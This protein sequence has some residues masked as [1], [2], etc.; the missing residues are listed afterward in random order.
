MSDRPRVSLIKTSPPGPETRRLAQREKVLFPEGA[1]GDFDER[2]FIAKSAAGSLIEDVDGNRYID[3]GSG[4]GTNN[5]GNCHPEV[6]E[7]VNAMMRQAGVTCWTSAGN[8]LQRLELAEKLLAV[9]PKRTNKVLFLTT[10]TE[11][12]EA[13]LRLMRRASGRPFVLSFFGQYHGLSYGAMAAGPLN[14]EVREDVA[15]LV[16]GFVYAPY[17]YAL[18][19]PLRSRTG[20]GAGRATLEFIEEMILTYEVPA[21]QIAGVLVEPVVGEAGVWVPPDDFLP[22]LREMCDRHGWYLCID[23]VQSGFGR[24]GKMWALEHWGVEP[25]LLVIGK[26]LSGG[27]MPIAAVAAEGKMMDKAHAFLAGTYAGH[28]AACAAGLKTIEILYRDRLFEHATSLGEY[29]LQRLQ[30]MQ[31]RYPVVGE[32]RGKGLWLAAEF[33]KDRKTQEKNFEAAAEVNRLCLKS[34]LYYIADSISWFSR[35]QPP[36]NIDRSLFEQGLDIFEE[37]VRTVNA[38]HPVK[39]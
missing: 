7:A 38:H 31:E 33:V 13:A 5:I 15:P 4:W 37:A 3:F 17:P 34:G 12:V 6:V 22:G 29:G 10:G 26:G 25:D 2:V 8:S 14:S 39:R 19:T 36:L 21:S 18:R 9:C 27:S 32:V 11:A 30:Q 24:C 1:Y 35:F 20:G 23:E 16:N 28:P